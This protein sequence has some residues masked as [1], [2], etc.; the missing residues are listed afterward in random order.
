MK[1]F[2]QAQSRSLA[3]AAILMA[4]GAMAAVPD[5]NTVV[6][7]TPRSPNDDEARLAA[8]EAKRQRKAEKRKAIAEK[9]AKRKV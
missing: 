6:D 3:V 8:A 1:R 4:A 9:L 5:V 2:S 7:W